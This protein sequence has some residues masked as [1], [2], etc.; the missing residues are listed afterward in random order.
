MRRNY[1][2]LIVINVCVL[3][4]CHAQEQYLNYYLNSTVLG[5]TPPNIIIDSN[6][7]IKYGDISVDPTAINRINLLKVSKDSISRRL[8]VRIQKVNGNDFIMGM[9]EDV[10]NYFYGFKFRNDSVWVKYKTTEIYN[11]TYTIT[12]TFELVSCK[13][14]MVWLR[15]GVQQVVS[16]DS[17]LNDA[18]AIVKHFNS[19]EPK[20]YFDYQFQNF[21]SITPPNPPPD[22]TPI[23]YEVN[24]K[25]NGS[26]SIIGDFKT[27]R[28]FYKEKYNITAGVNDS[29][30]CMVFN[31]NR[32][33]I[34]KDVK[35]AN[36][37]GSNF[38]TIDLTGLLAPGQL[39]ILEL[40]N[41]NK[42]E[43]YYLKFGYNL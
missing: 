13:S 20:G 42:N 22:N 8:K 25:P 23:F 41:I 37:F 21:C 40:T 43:K 5:N 15:N 2:I 31:S 34:L 39:Y 3:F 36:N 10:T 29:V 33:S 32:S 16:P 7:Y 12:D 38:K 17:I 11:N 24:A 18:N 30:R 9:E 35:L 1:F 6:S 28:F 26:F 14:S 19:N 27:L 4:D